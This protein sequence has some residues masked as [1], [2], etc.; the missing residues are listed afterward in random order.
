[1]EYQNDISDNTAGQDG[2]GLYISEG[3][4]PQIGLHTPYPWPYSNYISSNTAGRYGG[5]IY[6]A[7]GSDPLILNN[8]VSGNDALSG[9]GIYCAADAEIGDGT[10]EGYNS[11]SSNEATLYGGGIW[12]TDGS[13]PT[14]N[15]NGLYSNGAQE[16]GGVYC[17]VGAS[18]LLAGCSINSNEADY[19][20]GV[21]CI[22]ATPSFSSITDVGYND[23]YVAG[24]GMYV[25]GDSVMMIEG[26]YVYYNAAPEGSG[27]YSIDSVVELQ[28]STIRGHTCAAPGAGVR[29]LNTEL[30]MDNTVILDNSVPS[31][32]GG[33]VYLAE[34]STLSM[35]G[36][37]VQGNEAKLG[38][39][40]YVDDATAS[41]VSDGPFNNVVDNLAERGAGMYCSADAEVTI[42]MTRFGESY[43]EQGAG[44]YCAPGATPVVTNCLFVGN[45][46]DQ[47]AGVYCAAGSAPVLTDLSA[48]GNVATA[49]AAGI[50]SDDPGVAIKNC[51]FWLN[52]TDT[53]GVTATYSCISESAPGEGNFGG[54][55]L[56]VGPVFS[57]TWP[58]SQS[59]EYTP[60]SFWIPVGETLFRDVPGVTRD[61]FVGMWLNPAIETNT[62]FLI[63]EDTITEEGDTI[64]VKGNATGLGLE[65]GEFRIWDYHPRSTGGHWTAG[66]WVADSVTSPCVDAGDP[67]D[68]YPNEPAPNGGRINMGAYGNTYQASRGTGHV[69]YLRA[70]TGV[71]SV[72]HAWTLVELTEDFVDPVIV[73]GPAT[74]NEWAQGVVRMRNVTGS[75][76]EI[77]FQEWDYLD[78]SHLE[79]QIRWLAVERGTFDLS[80]GRQIVA[81][82]LS[83]SNTNVAAPDWVPFAE[84]FADTPVALAQV[85][86]Y[87]DATAVTDRICGVA[88]GGINLALQVQEASSGHGEEVVGY[89]AVSE[90]AD[91]IA[92]LT[93]DVSRTDVE[94]TH[95]PFDLVTDWLVW[96]S[97]EQSDDQET[98]HAAEQ[99]GFISFES[100]EPPFAADMQTCNESDTANLRCAQCIVSVQSTPITGISIDGDPAAFDGVTDYAVAPAE[101]VA[102]DLTAPGT[103]SVGDTDYTFDKWVLDDV[104][105]T[106]GDTTV[107]FVTGGAT[108]AV[109]V[110]TRDEWTLNVE[111]TPITGVLIDGD[112]DSCDGTTDYAV[113]LDDNLEVSLT[114][115]ATHSVGDTDYT[116]VKWVLNAVD[117]PPGDTTV[118]FFINEATTATAVYVRDQWTLTVHST[119]ISGVAIDGDPDSCDGT[120]DYAVVLDDNTEV[121]LTAP[122]THSVGDTDYTF[123]KWVL[124]AVDQPP[125]DTTVSFF[126]NETTTATAVYVRDQWTLTVQSTPITGV[127]IAGTP[128]GTTNYSQ[129]L[130][131]NS[132]VS[133]TAPETVTEGE[134]VYVFNR[135][136]LN[137]VDQ[138]VGQSTLTFMI[139]EATTVVAGYS[140]LLEHGVVAT[141][142]TW[143]T[144]PFTYSFDRV[145][146]VVAGPATNNDPDP[147]V[148]RI[149]NVSK[150]SFQIKFQEWDYLSGKHKKEKIAWL[151]VSKGTQALGRANMIAAGTF[152]TKSMSVKKPKVVMFPQAFSKQ[153]AVIA[154][155]QGVNGSRAVTERICKVQKDR[156]SAII[157]EQ[158]AG[159]S[160]P[161]ETIGYVAVTK[162]TTSLAGLPCTAGVTSRSVTHKPYRI[163]TAQGSCRVYVEEEQSLDRE[164]KH[165]KEEVGYIA[166]GGTPLLVAD[167]QT[168]AEV[169]TAVVRYR[170]TLSSAS[171]CELAISAVDEEGEGLFGAVIALC[172]GPTE[173]TTVVTGPEP[174]LHT[175]E[176]GALV[177]LE[178]QESF[179]GA[180][181]SLSFDH[182]ELDGVPAEQGLVAVKAEMTA[183]RKAVAV[184]RRITPVPQ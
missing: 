125:G 49:G 136:T 147:G 139:N 45:S 165:A 63:V 67:A 101:G 43:A 39:G 81:G 157:Q 87:N 111:S 11:I 98:G 124:N 22:E 55:P 94:V 95:V 135:W 12:I 80:E 167:I 24:G 177:T 112:P 161:K 129:A 53:Y 71:V 66:G 154:Q 99:V 131:D 133:L 17:D 4:A 84:P 32:V 170:E 171:T 159:G 183:D 93:C 26:A 9:G 172:E 89:I 58:T 182:W 160:H 28:R 40:I 141:K 132:E 25:T 119:P 169:D 13:A 77:R 92:T 29:A 174:A 20:G 149:R 8:S 118:S 62:Q 102:V 61:Q 96:V 23:A 73:A 123:V 162:G 173:P 116:F 184:Y 178:A 181:G 114:A 42:A 15:N 90:G 50:H 56:L 122:A 152:T 76:F 31:D 168:C 164:V 33:G 117:Q 52:N 105:Q 82:S 18:P 180:A 120:T 163:T 78:D 108:K 74:A 109:A 19:G 150:A 3:S 60:C 86:T 1:M 75:S 30:T 151:A 14:L 143:T 103:H 16:G 137:G 176:Q 130:D 37:T 166:F 88:V 6:C 85:M 48:V 59:S 51:V 155:V 7:Q 134:R 110:Y 35:N 127:E 64:V 41:V 153:P 68:E 65:G 21:R 158:E 47:G 146:V 115:P 38:G 107:S 54:D 126:I 144:V 69:P 44:I 113:A 36:T 138:P 72:S 27:L 128:E 175:F 100:D 79:E 142:D 70:E 104:D 46:A 34:G 5:G 97:E 10:V 145:P 91:S 121:S 57:G 179:A 156:F 140:L 106:P 2:G 148:V 83:T